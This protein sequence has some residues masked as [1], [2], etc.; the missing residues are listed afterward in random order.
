MNIKSLF[1]ILFVSSVAQAQNTQF[2]LQPNALNPATAGFF[3][4]FSVSGLGELE[5]TASINRINSTLNT[6]LKIEKIKGGLGANYGYIGF[7]D[8]YRHST[9]EI[10]YSY[11]AIEKE[12]FRMAFG[13]GLSIENDRF[14]TNT[15]TDPDTYFYTTTSTPFL[16]LGTVA[17]FG[18]HTGQFSVR[19]IRF[20]NNLGSELFLVSYAYDWKVN[21]DFSMKLG[22]LFSSQNKYNSLIFSTL[23][24][25]KMIW[26]NLGLTN[27]DVLAV[28][29]GVDIKDNL[30][31]GA[32][33]NTYFSPLS[34]ITDSSL[35]MFLS[36]R[37]KHKEKAIVTE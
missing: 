8:M 26:L 4:Q 3:N 32:F 20:S 37:I 35:G 6:N 25:Y 21:D 13:T 16:S 15:I 9:G 14:K 19:N 36:Y 33:Y 12:R 5:K 2:M 27:T 7:S 29:A 31:I 30:R 28:G 11:H 18:N 34:K 10:N 24:K 1:I 17:Q 22:L 23:F